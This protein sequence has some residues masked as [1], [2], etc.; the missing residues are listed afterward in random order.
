METYCPDGDRTPS[1]WRLFDYAENSG[2][3]GDF[4]TE[5]RILMAA[6]NLFAS[7]GYA[8]T[9]VREIVDAAGVTKPTLYY[10]FK[11]KEDLYRKLMDQCIETFFRIMEQALAR[12][13]DLRSRL[14]AFYEHIYLLFHANIDFLRL[15]NSM[16]YGPP[17]ATPTYDLR[18]RNLRF[19]KLLNEMLDAGATAGEF[20]QENREEVLLLLLGLI[21]SMQVQL[22]FKRSPKPFDDVK[23][24]QRVI[25]LI[26]DGA[27]VSC[28]GGEPQP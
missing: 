21:R 6:A 28:C 12:P 19:E 10:Y 18:S 16:I 2:C 14:T 20:K 3:D 25:N 27:K 26:F 1:D 4:N 24:I 8:G 5:A 17:G 7:K 22:V 23:T 15:V 11:N 13:G 9:A